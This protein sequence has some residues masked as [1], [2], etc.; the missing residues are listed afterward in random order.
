MQFVHG[1]LAAVYNLFVT[2]LTLPHIPTK[3][4]RFITSLS[5]VYLHTY[6]SVPKYR[7]PWVFQ[8]TTNWLTFSDPL[9]PC[10]KEIGL[11]SAM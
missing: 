5:L 11:K 3:V 10:W 8:L 1:V 6:C 2:G 4:L 7:K 9:S